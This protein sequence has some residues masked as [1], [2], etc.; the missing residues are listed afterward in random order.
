MWIVEKSASR[1][2]LTR[3]DQEIGPCSLPC[4]IVSRGGLSLSLSLLILFNSTS[5]ADPRID[6]LF[7]LKESQYF[8]ISSARQ[9]LHSL[10]G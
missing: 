9:T 1:D 10:N 3:G 4:V 6:F 7:P 5:D 8:G 2:F